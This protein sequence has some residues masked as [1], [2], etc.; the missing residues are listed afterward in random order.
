MHVLYF[1]VSTV[2]AL[3]VVTVSRGMICPVMGR[4]V[5]GFCTTYLFV[6]YIRQ[7]KV[8]SMMKVKVFEDIEYDESSNYSNQGHHQLS[9][10][11]RDAPISKKCSFFEH[12]SKGL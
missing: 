11:I 4:V 1:L 12:C 9:R 8:S 2:G 5:D 10:A 6:K 3:V 7:K